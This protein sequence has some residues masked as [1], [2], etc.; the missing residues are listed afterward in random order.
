MRKTITISIL[1]V[2]TLF[3]NSCASRYQTINPESLNYVSRSLENNILLEYKYDLLAQ[4][5]KKKETENNIKMVAVKITN[6]SDKE[7]VFGRDFTFT[8]ANGTEVSI[9]EA[10]GI[11]KTVKQSPASYLWYLLL[12]PVQFFSGTTTTT[13]G[14][15]QDNRTSFPI[16]VIIGPGLAGGNLITASTANKKLKRELMQYDLYGKIIKKGETAYGLVGINS[17]SYEA[18]KIKMLE[19]KQ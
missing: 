19:S 9:I 2:F 18:I 6:T 14:H 12:T 16:G 17:S 8:Y 3:L 15:V 5:Y 7:I 4:K 10:E 13:N 1:L 11:F